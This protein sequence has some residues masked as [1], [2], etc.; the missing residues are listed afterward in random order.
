MCKFCNSKKYTIRIRVDE[1]IE[2]EKKYIAENNFEV[3]YCPMCGRK[4]GGE[5]K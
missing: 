2:N 1:W 3:F 4:L 5:E